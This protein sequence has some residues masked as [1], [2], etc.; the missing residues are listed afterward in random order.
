[1][2]TA[3]RIADMRAVHAIRGVYTAL[4]AVEGITTLDVR[5]GAAVIEHDGRAT[6][7]ALRNALEAAGYRVLEVRIENRRLPVSGES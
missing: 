3:L 6:E 4:S 1:V 7:E 5:L 2:V